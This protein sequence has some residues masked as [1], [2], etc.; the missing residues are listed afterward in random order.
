MRVVG[1]FSNLGLNLVLVGVVFALACDS[2]DRRGGNPKNAGDPV[3]ARVGSGAIT[4]ADLVGVRG[5]SGDSRRQLEAVIARRLAAEEAQ[6]RGLGDTDEMRARL[7][8]NRRQAA[9]KEEEI[10]R[11]ALFAHMKSELKL[12]DQD[13]REYYEKT[14]VR[15]ATPQLHLRRV[16]F[17]SKADADV[18]LSKPVAQLDLDPKGSEEIG[19]TPIDKL[20]PTILPEV[21]QLHRPGDRV[22]VQRGAEVSIVELVEILP[23]EPRPFEEVRGKVEDSLRTLRAQ[24]IFTKEMERLRLEA[25]IEIDEEALRAL[26]SQTASPSDG[27]H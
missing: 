12:S 6:R 20:S 22:V 26:A 7:A 19:P 15:F 14:K 9:A 16:A 4:T 17:T 13:L 5:A 24:E 8:A 25:K 27:R 1:K 23:A 10:L 11:D 3:L 2:A 18:A 21:L